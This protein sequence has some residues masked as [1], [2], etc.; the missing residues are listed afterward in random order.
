VSNKKGIL[1]ITG[2]TLSAANQFSC[3]SRK[4]YCSNKNVTLL[5]FSL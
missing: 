3:G 5:W 2:I 1:F 4:S